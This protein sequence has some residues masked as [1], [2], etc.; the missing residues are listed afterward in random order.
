M[1]L[2]KVAAA[3]V[4]VGI[5]LAAGLQIGARHPASRHAPMAGAMSAHRAFAREGVDVEFGPAR[6]ALLTAS[7]TE[8][9]GRSID[10][11]DLSPLGLSFLGGRLLSS[12][13]GP[14]GMFLFAEPN[15][16]R[17]AVYLKSLADSRR[18]EFASRREGDVEAYFW[19]DGRLG[20]AITGKAHSENLAAAANIVRTTYRK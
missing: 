1:R 13:E 7:V 18:V 15:G 3:A 20:Y 4:L 9:L 17:I 11:P 2:R 5:G 16:N 10:I 14:G 19:L 12:D 8:H 6:L